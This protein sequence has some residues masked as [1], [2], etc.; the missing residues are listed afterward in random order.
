MKYK[1]DKKKGILAAIWFLSALLLAGCS[2][3]NAGSSTAESQTPADKDTGFI[4]AG[5]GSFDSA[6]TAVIVKIDSEAKKITFLNLQVSRNYTLQYDGT[7]VFS[8]KYGQPMSSDQLRE[9]DIVDVTFLKSK[10]RLASL[11][12]SESGWTNATVSRYSI[13]TASH[14]VTIGDDIYKITK[15]T[16]I[17]SD[18]EEIEIIDLNNADILT[19]NGIDSTVYSIVVEKG[20]GYLRLSGDE[21]FIGGWIEVGQ[22]II[23]Q[24]TEDMLLTVPEGSYQVLISVTGGGGSKN[25]IINR[26][27]EITL[28]ISD[29][30]IAKPQYGQV[31][32]A[33]NPS[34]ARLYV[35]G[36]LVDVSGAVTLEYGIH[37]L[38]AMADGYSTS[39]SYLKVAEESAGIEITL[40]LEDAED[41]EDEEEDVSGGD[42]STATGYYQVYIDA[43]E[44]AEV[45]VDGNYVGI[46]PV[47]FK[48]EEGSHVITLRKTGYETRSYTIQVD[49]EDKDVTYSFAELSPD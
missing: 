5:P 9:G 7:T 32:F 2:L 12:L 42:S 16:K 8:D 37:Q 43:P 48:K 23:H 27:E 17:F 36:N 15:D 14:D 44:G 4:L 18:G 41:E 26:N 33:M 31:I 45:Y 49:G 46:S 19:F 20:H 34:S 21:N 25:V 40:D 3:K 30:E 13:N 22:N 1:T 47:S 24:I 10:K 28:D 11:T 38:I 35:D 29:L 39:T 6:D